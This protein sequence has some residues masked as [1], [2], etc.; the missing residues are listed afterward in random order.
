MYGVFIPIDKGPQ[1]NTDATGLVCSFVYRL[2]RDYGDESFVR[3]FWNMYVFLVALLISNLSY[4]AIHRVGYTGSPL[5]AVDYSDFVSAYNASTSGDTIQVYGNVTINNPGVTISKKIIIQGFG[6]NFDVHPN[7]QVTSLDA[8]SR[9]LGNVVLTFEPGSEGSVIEGCAIISEG[10]LST[11]IRIANSNITIRK[12]YISA[13]LENQLRQISDTKIESCVLNTLNEINQG[14]P[15]INTYISNCILGNNF[16]FY[17][18]G[19]TGSVVNCVQMPRGSYN[20]LGFL[21]LN[22]ASFLVKNC[23]FDYPYPMPNAPKTIWENCFFRSPQPAQLPMGKNNRW[24]QSYANL[25]EMLGSASVIPGQFY[26][27]DC[28]SC[29]LLPNPLFN[30]NFYRLKTNSP[31]KNAGFDSNGNPTDCGIFGGDSASLYKLGGVPAIP[32]IYKLSASS[33]EATTNPYKVIIGVH[34]NS[35]QNVTRVEYYIDNDSGFGKAT[36]IA[37]TPGID[38]DSLAVQINLERLSP[39]QHMFHVRAQD[40]AGSWSLVTSYSFLN[41]YISPTATPQDYMVQFDGVNDYLDL[42]TWFNQKSFTLS[43]WVNPDS[44]QTNGAAI[45]A[46]QNDLYLYANPTAKNNYILAHLLQFDLLPN[47]W[48]HVTITVDGTTNTRKVYLFGQLIDTN[49]WTYAPQ[50]GFNL[51]FGNGGF[52]PNSYFKGALDE[53][54]LWNRVL[55]SDSIYLNVSKPLNGNEAGLLGYWNFNNGCDAIAPDITVNNHSATLKNSLAKVPSTVPSIGQQIVPNKAGQG[56]ITVKIYDNFLRPGA[57]A[58]LT[59][60]GFADIIAD[61]TIVTDSGTIATC[62][63]NLA[64]RDSGLY[65]LVISNPNNQVKAYNNSFT[66]TQVD[67]SGR[68]NVQLLGAN[69]FRRGRVYKFFIVYQ[70]TGN[71]DVEAPAFALHSYNRNY[72]AFSENDLLYKWQILPV[73]LG[74]RIGEDGYNGFSNSDTVLSPGKTYSIPVYAMDS[75]SRSGRFS[76]GRVASTCD[77]LDQ[78]VL[79]GIYPNRPIEYNGTGGGLVPYINN[80]HNYIDGCSNPQLMVGY[81]N[82][83]LLGHTSNDVNWN[84]V[85]QQACVVH[86]QCYQTCYKKAIDGSNDYRP[87][88]ICD[89]TMFNIMEDICRNYPGNKNDCKIAALAYYW[90]LQLAGKAAFDANQSRC[91]A[92]VGIDQPPAGTGSTYLA[93]DCKNCPLGSICFGPK[94]ISSFDPNQKVGPSNFQNGK[95]DFSYLI[96]FENDSS[97]TAPAQE[98]TVI[99]TLDKTKFDISSFR[100]GLLGFGD[101]LFSTTNQLNKTFSQNIDL[102]PLKNLIVKAEGRLDSASGIAYWKFVSLDPTTM[103]LTD[104]PLEGFLPPTNGSSNKGTGW[105]SFSI[106]PIDSLTTGSSLQNRATIIFDLNSPIA[107]KAHVNRIDRILPISHV[108]PLPASQADSSFMVKW[109]GSDSISGVR[110]YNIYVAVDSST[111]T[112]WQSNVSDTFAIFTGHPNHQ[113]SFYSISTDS[114]GNVEAPKRIAETTTG[115][116][117]ALPLSLLDFTATLLNQKTTALNWQTTNEINT[118]V[119]EIEH[120]LDGLTFSTVGFVAANRSASLSNTYT[121]SH[122]LLSEGVHYY[123]VKIVDADGKFAYSKVLQVLLPINMHDMFVFFPNPANTSITIIGKNLKDIVVRDLEGRLILTKNIQSVYSSTLNLAGLSKGVYTLTGKSI[124]GGVV[125]KKLV[126]Y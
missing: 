10:S 116:F 97:A 2:R 79:D 7:L 110:N 14:Y 6:Y 5:A 100:F 16:N 27:D 126:I 117:K 58:K 81:I 37:I 125:T 72:I 104:N 43:F 94:P 124:S 35:Q 54:K 9:F 103:R 84:N 15:T 108:L 23:I 68:I 96:D 86:D 18:S 115:V 26:R 78:Y 34:S 98:V 29:T 107:T 40:A 59:R 39:C 89:E 80:G 36:P 93:P 123:R 83:T 60:N 112:L 90:G 42:G 77:D 49:V 88:N 53:I 17:H 1:P 28:S 73:F 51:R 75:S 66:I 32:S 21:S 47:Q 45:A 52:F 76:S 71:V 48:N 57:T 102:R 33:A 67:T 121:F 119:F 85:F 64:G 11:F 44:I 13:T 111:F 69:V 114:A 30:E 63:F 118:K 24:G 19:S 91:T 82:G 62:V 113:Y 12:C 56:P 25:F 3:N 50:N 105:V 109:Q 92:Q 99:D 65:N 74:N 4:A 41:K 22:S 101:T 95:Q 106:K 31:A 87:K 70:N 46:I 20:Y 61:K 38:L 55:S 120:S 122:S 8:P